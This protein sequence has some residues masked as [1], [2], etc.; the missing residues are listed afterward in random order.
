MTA[1]LYLCRSCFDAYAEACEGKVQLVNEPMSAMAQSPCPNCSETV[2]PG[3]GFPVDAK[4]F[5]KV[6]PRNNVFAPKPTPVEKPIAKPRLVFE[7]AEMRLVLGGGKYIVEV[8][9]RDSLGGYAWMVLGVCEDHLDIRLAETVDQLQ[10]EVNILLE[11][12]AKR[13]GLPVEPGQ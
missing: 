11:C 8:P 3:S 13:Q 2:D 12:E 10:S 4:H 7:N 9:H 5:D 6:G 1:P